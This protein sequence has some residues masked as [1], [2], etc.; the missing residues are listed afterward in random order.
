[1]SKLRIAE[2]VMFAV[3]VILTAARSVVDYIRSM[4]NDT[5]ESS[6]GNYVFD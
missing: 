3:S 4:G 6:D 1:M 5:T 2:I